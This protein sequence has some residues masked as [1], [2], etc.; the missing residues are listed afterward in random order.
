L[1]IQEHIHIGE[2]INHTEQRLILRIQS[3]HMMHGQRMHL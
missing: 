1:I 2:N 3:T